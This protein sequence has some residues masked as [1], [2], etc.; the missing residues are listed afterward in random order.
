MS[1]IKRYD[2][3]IYD[4]VRGH[5]DGFFDVEPSYYTISSFFALVPLFLMIV[6]LAAFDPIP[7]V[8][9]TIAVIG[10]LLSFGLAAHHIGKFLDAKNEWNESINNG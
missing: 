6:T 1:L 2:Q 9:I 3:Y 4:D 10:G 7:P 8:R 5:N